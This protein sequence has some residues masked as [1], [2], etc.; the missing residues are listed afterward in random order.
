MKV[1]HKKD[2]IVCVVRYAKVRST[3]VGRSLDVQDL[4]D[5]TQFSI[6]GTEL[7]DS[8]LSA[9]S[10]NET[11][12]VSLTE[13]ATILSQSY[14]VPFTVVFDK[15][16]GETRKLRG[17]LIKPEPILGR[18]T[19]QDLDTTE[20]SPIRLVDNRTLSELIVRGVK[21]TIK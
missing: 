11:K 2:D 19:V 21:Y 18:C 6:H 16:D 5:K 8:L 4:D 1:I 7:V 10:Y 17:R 20:G 12:K 15:K 9:D 14:N 13:M 3:G